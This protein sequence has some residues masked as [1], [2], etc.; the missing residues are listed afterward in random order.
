MIQERILQPITVEAR[1]YIPCR[2]QPFRRLSKGVL[3]LSS[4]ELVSW[5]ETS[6]NELS[7]LQSF[8][9]LCAT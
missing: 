4:G 1:Q 6:E 9:L 7:L 8:S 5:D 2:F 3:T